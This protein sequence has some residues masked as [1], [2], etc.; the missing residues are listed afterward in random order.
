M[1]KYMVMACHAAVAGVFPVGE[2]E[3]RDETVAFGRAYGLAWDKGFMP[4]TVEL[5]EVAS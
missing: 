4:D 3:G 2:V 5:E 1:K